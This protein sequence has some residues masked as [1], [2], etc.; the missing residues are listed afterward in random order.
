MAASSEF[1]RVLLVEDAFDQAIML[2]SFLPSDT[3]EVVHTQDGD[4]A[5]RL[6][7][8]QRWDI[9]ITDLNL[10]GADGFEVIREARKLNP[11]MPVLAT[12]GYTGS[13]YQ[14]QAF[15]AGASELMTKPIDRDEFHAKV[16]ELLGHRKSRA[17]GAV[18]AVGGLVGD[19]EMG[20]GGTLMAERAAGHEV[21]IVHLC[22]DERDPEGMGLEGA[23]RAAEFLD[24]RVILDRGAMEHTTGRVALLEQVVKDIAPTRAYIPAMDESHPAR[25]EA[26]RI[27]KSSTGR[28]PEVY[29]YQ[30]ATTGLAFRPDRFVD[31]GDRMVMK[32]EAL[33]AY[34]MAGAGR[35]DL[36]PRMAQAYARYWG[37][38]REFSEV[39]AFE[40]LRGE[41]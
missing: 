18:L 2:R 40:V 4:Q 15:R 25:M 33:A 24:C 35:L 32:M 39:E 29:S 36:A 3:Y 5:L 21:T 13:A 8:S 37:R 9:L 10:P 12:T 6:L 17:G 19:V 28:T 16:D 38:F 1:L 26:F 30:S 20:C 41:A 23:K 27:A 14:E 34:H 22:A 31:V 7:R 11:G